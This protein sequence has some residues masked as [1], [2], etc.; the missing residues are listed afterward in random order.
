ML[1][2][3]YPSYSPIAWYNRALQIDDASLELTLLQELL[4]R[5]PAYYPGVLLFVRNMCEPKNED[6]SNPVVQ[7]LQRRNFLR[8]ISPAERERLRVGIDRAYT[9]LDRAIQIA[10]D[11]EK[12]FYLERLRLDSLSSHNSGRTVG[13][14]WALLER[15]PEDHDVLLYAMWFFLQTGSGEAAFS[16]NNKVSNRA[17]DPFTA[18]VEL[19]VVGKL[20][21]ASEAFEKC[22]KD[23]LYAFPALANTAKIKVKL[24][25]RAS[26]I[27]LYV[28]SAGLAPNDKT[29]SAVHYEAALLMLQERMIKET[30]RTLGYCVQLDPENRRAWALLKE[31]EARN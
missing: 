8:D 12:R 30:I 19:A 7:E 20:T 26:A 10:G 3:S 15:Y 13:D 17:P 24:D 1:T 5:F 2:E 25:D 27:E 16:L 18:G 29:A 9:A 22:A 14:L 4:E 21:E 6:P 11:G 23:E 31:L 28:R